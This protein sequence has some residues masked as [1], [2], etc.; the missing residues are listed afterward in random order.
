MDDRHADFLR[1][2]TSAQPA[3][4]R[5]VLGHVRDFHRAEDVLQEVAVVLWDRFPE[6]VAGESFERWAFGVARHKILRS[7]RDRE[8]DRLVLTDVMADR[9][10]ERL[11]ALGP[12]HDER[13]MFLKACLEKLP[14]RSRAAVE[15]R[16]A[17]QSSMAQVAAA[18]GGSIN[19]ARLLLCRTRRLL[20]RCMESTRQG[21]EVKWTPAPP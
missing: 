6:F 20:S 14:E 16:Y 7:W 5:F 10:A 17:R 21:E 1:R 18:L 11:C 8:R 3:L 9:F 2:F 19:A 13:R 4:R 15:L 12:Q